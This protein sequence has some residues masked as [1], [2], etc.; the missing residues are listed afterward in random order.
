MIRE[1]KT[2]HASVIIT[3]ES[4]ILQSHKKGSGEAAKRCDVFIFYYESVFTID[5]MRAIVT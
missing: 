2:L 1:K 4:A 3:R 5:V